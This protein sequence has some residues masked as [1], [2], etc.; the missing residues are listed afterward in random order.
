MQR[1]FIITH[2][3]RSSRSP[4]KTL[5]GENRWPLWTCSRSFTPFM[6]IYV[7]RTYVCNV[8][9]T[10]KTWIRPL[11]SQELVKFRK[12]IEANNIEF[13]Q[14]CTR[15]GTTIKFSNTK[16]KLTSKKRLKGN[17]YEYKLWTRV[18]IFLFKPNPQLCMLNFLLLQLMSIELYPTIRRL[19]YE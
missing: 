2:L 17:S 8:S 13:I 16:F 4:Q 6:I 10:T 11:R 15:W 9:F 12:A 14:E 1:Q 3:S 19:L 18:G 5:F 7:K